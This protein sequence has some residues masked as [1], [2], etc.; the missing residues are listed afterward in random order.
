MKVFPTLH[1]EYLYVPMREITI[2]DPM[3][4]C[5]GAIAKLES[6]EKVVPAHAP[7]QKEVP[8][9]KG[10]A[11]SHPESRRIPG[12]AWRILRR[13]IGQ[14][15]SISTLSFLLTGRRGEYLRVVGIIFMVE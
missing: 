8:S 4:G 15:S 2:P 9:P 1:D 3:A 6:C 5:Y 12:I 14:T 13:L 7:L 10:V 11:V